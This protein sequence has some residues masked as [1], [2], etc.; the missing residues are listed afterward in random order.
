MVTSWL[1]LF[2]FGHFFALALPALSASFPD[3]TPRPIGSVAIIH[4]T[5]MYPNLAYSDC[6][7]LLPHLPVDHMPSTFSESTA[8]Y[9]YKLP[10]VYDNGH[11]K[12]TF[13]LVQGVPGAMGDWRE[14]MGVNS[15]WFQYARTCGIPKSRPVRRLFPGVVFWGEDHRIETHITQHEYRTNA[16]TNRT[17]LAALTAGILDSSEG[18]VL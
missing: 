17:A 3:F 16:T 5:S 7:P 1:L 11:C 13:N 2:T 6:L 8:D 15:L 14:W 9:R 4:C 10:K 12:I 18:V